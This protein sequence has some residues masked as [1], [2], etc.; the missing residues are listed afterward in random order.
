MKIRVR[1]GEAKGKI[2][3]IPSKSYAHRILLCSALSL[4]EVKVL[5]LIGSKDILTTKNALSSLGVG[6][7]ETE[8]G[9]VVTPLSYDGGEKTVFCDESGST[10][11]F[12]LPV[13]SALGIS[14]TVDGKEGLRKR[15]I[16][17]LLDVLRSGGAIIEGDG[18]PVKMSGKLKAGKY[19]LDGSQSSQNLTG[20]MYA[21][22]LLD[23][24]SEIILMNKLVSVGYVDITLDVMRSFGACIDKTDSGYTVYPS[25]FSGVDT[26]YVEG[27]Y[28]SA[29]FLMALGV[30]AGEVEITGLNAHSKQGDRAMIDVLRSM[31]A[32]IEVSDSVI[33]RKSDLRAIDL[34]ATDIPDLIPV[35][36]VCCAFSDGVSR[37][38]GVDRLKIKE[39]DRLQAICDMLDNFGVKHSDEP[40]TLYIY[41]G[42]VEGCRG[43]LKGYNDHRIVMSAAVMA[44]V[45][46]DATIDDMEAINKSYPTFFEDLKVLGGENIAEVLG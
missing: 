7:K 37:I 25:K 6:F 2:A 38:R 10:L 19:V 18:L 14:A 17:L 30:L 4:H 46:G 28:S 36:A 39:S 20:L 22:S 27:D 3:I 15:P 34:D 23:E 24:P 16:K 26:A 35:I 44:T 5:G 33:C 8:D 13:I 32:D 40:D 43:T 1:Q 9:L 45:A 21:L 42:R 41:G 11:R 31:G 12:L 29:S